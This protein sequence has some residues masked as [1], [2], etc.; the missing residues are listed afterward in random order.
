PEA[1]AIGAVNTLVF[2]D[3]RVIG[4]NTDAAGF[5]AALRAEGI[6]PAGKRTVVL[7]AGGSA[8]A[9]LAALAPAGAR[10]T[11]ANRT[12]SRARELAAWAQTTGGSPV[13]AVPMEASALGPAVENA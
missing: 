8:R 5:L 11:V 13:Q 10:I 6:E 9:V 1:A 12:V 2:R 7:G 4:H 3:G